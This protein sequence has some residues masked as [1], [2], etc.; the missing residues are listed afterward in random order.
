MA[1]VHQIAPA[2]IMRPGHLPRRVDLRRGDHHLGQAPSQ[3]QPGQQLRVRAISFTRSDGPRG[4]LPGAITCIA[5]PSAAAALYSPHPPKL[6]YYWVHHLVTYAG[7]RLRPRGQSDY[8]RMS[9]PS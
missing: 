8:D 2:R 5:I 4:V 3:Q 1:S 6:S 9:G 7:W